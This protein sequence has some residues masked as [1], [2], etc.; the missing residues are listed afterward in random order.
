MANSS[1]LSQLND[2]VKEL[3]YLAKHPDQLSD[4][5]VIA[6]STTPAKSNSPTHQSYKYETV[7]EPYTYDIT[8][9]KVS[10]I[11]NA[12]I[13]QFQ[14]LNYDTTKGAQEI[15]GSITQ[16]ATGASLQ[17]PGDS[18]G[19]VKDTASYYLE[20]EKGH[21][22]FQVSASESLQDVAT[23]LS[24]LTPAVGVQAKVVGGNLV[25]SNQRLGSSS[26][27]T[28]ERTDQITT[29][30]TGQNTQQIANINVQHQN[31]ESTETLSGSVLSQA[32]SAEL[33]YQGTTGGTIAGTAA[34]RVT[35][36]QGSML[37]SVTE[38]ETLGAVATRLNQQTSNTGVVVTQDGN[39]LRF[40]SSQLGA[41]QTVRIDQLVQEEAIQVTGR[42]AAQVATF[43]VN[44]LTRGSTEVLNGQVQQS[45][46]KGSLTLAGTNGK[47]I[48]SANFQL[49]GAL[50]TSSIGITKD[51]SLSSVATRINNLTQNTGVTAR[52]SSNN[53]L[54]ESAQYGTAG[55]VTVDS[56]N[57]PYQVNV[58]GVNAVQISSFNV[59]SFTDG[60]TQAFTGSVSAVA[61]Y[62]E[63]HF[64]GNN[65]QVDENASITIKGNLG[66]KQFTVSKTQ[67]LANFATQI[68]NQSSSTGVTARV[69]GDKIFFTS[70]QAGSAQEVNIK[71]N[72][73]TFD[74]KGDNAQ[75]SVFGK[76]AK[77]K[78]NGVD[79]V[80]AG[81]QFSFSDA[82]GSYKFTVVQDFKATLSQ[83]NVTS[84]AGT[85]SLSGGNGSGTAHGSDVAAVVNG[86]QYTGTGNNLNVS[87]VQGQYSLSFAAGF[88]GTFN[89]I[90]AKSVL[91]EF[92]FT[93]G[94]QSGSA[95]GQDF[96]A[97]IN[98]LDYHSR[99]SSVNVSTQTGS[100]D[101]AFAPEQ[102]G[103]F[104]PVTISTHGEQIITSAYGHDAEAT[105]NGKNLTAVGNRFQY[106][107]AALSFTF[108]ATVGFTGQIDPI[109]IAS[110]KSTVTTTAKR[111]ITVPIVNQPVMAESAPVTEP[112]AKTFGFARTLGGNL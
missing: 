74:V 104:D 98:G 77:A 44:S 33:V 11:N 71:V 62:A 68:N 15:R 6:A 59:Q 7:E 48:S 92:T 97:R 78:I 67:T 60:A 112:C 16:T 108:N 66:S 51:E 3:R 61:E 109:K 2:V 32:K 18:N 23:R 14:L 73:G 57:L 86:V 90:T 72:S 63:S 42:N 40:N 88:T 35:G 21:L 12:Q 36:T 58:S 55:V 84:T 79:L 10:G 43:N 8:Q 28:L 81:N 17:V 111:T 106:E 82:K 56:L 4:A 30:V 26:R 54:L 110:E 94:D 47:V 85:F 39:N 1:N 31:A 13:N 103:A 64:D 70:A 80:A 53:L 46:T 93:G 45:A 52:V 91:D 83:I 69:T 22:N 24:N 101:L 25:F 65:G 34:F 50:G 95:G 99:N 100:Y 102:L 105:L 75:G 9:S 5:P 27:I 49:S 29:K 38:G 107:D 87:G 19:L 37:V 89:S 20:T 96:I 76:D 41:D